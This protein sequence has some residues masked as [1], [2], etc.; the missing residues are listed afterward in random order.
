MTVAHRASQA[1]AEVLIRANSPQ[2]ASQVVAEALLR[3]NPPLYASQVVL[4]ALVSAGLVSQQVLEVLVAA[5]LASQLIAEILVWNRN[6]TTPAIFPT[7]TLAGLGYSVIK[8]PRA[9]VGQATAG[10]GWNVR[11]GYAANPIWEWEL[12]YDLLSDAI[13]PSDL[14]LLL[15]FWL[16][17]NGNL[18]PF[19]F[20]DPDD[21][22]V[23]GQAIG[24]TDGST[25]NY[26]LVR[27]YGGSSGSGTE[28]VGYVNTGATFN[29]YLAGVLQSASTYTVLTTTP[30]AQVL[31]FN[32]APTSGKAITVDMSYYYYARLKDD[33]NDFEKFMYQLWSLK[34]LTLQSLRG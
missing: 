22:S 30:V 23:T 6:V 9:F 19:L 17:C 25:T 26:T 21:N 5:G 20:L 29:V 1:V 15:G 32:S 31:K 4:E 34:K 12:T 3:A 11:I 28:P 16:A 13:S 27:T 8:R 14:K 24:T 10:S 33:T 2:Y 18:T 7:T